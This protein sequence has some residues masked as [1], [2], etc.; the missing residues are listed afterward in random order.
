[1]WIAALRQSRGELADSNDA[2][3][4]TELK[5]STLPAVDRKLA[6]DDER[7]RVVAILNDLQQIALLFGQQRFRTPIVRG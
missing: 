7:A 2:V 1:V 6:G 3:P 5:A 4:A